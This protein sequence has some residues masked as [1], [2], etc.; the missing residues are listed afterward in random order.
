MNP[1]QYKEFLGAL[2]E[3]DKRPKNVC[4]GKDNNSFAKSPWQQ[5]HNDTLS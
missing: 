5:Y 4:F 3:C 2:T 1:Q